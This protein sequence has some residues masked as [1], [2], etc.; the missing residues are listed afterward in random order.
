[1]QKVFG[2]KRRLALRLRA[3]ANQTTRTGAILYGSALVWLAQHPRQSSALSSLCM[4][5]VT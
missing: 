4:L 5:L 2:H 3:R 1:M